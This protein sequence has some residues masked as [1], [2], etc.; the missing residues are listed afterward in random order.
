MTFKN[1]LK[2]VEAKESVKRSATR[3]LH[4]QGSE[5]IWSTYKRDQTY[6]PAPKISSTDSSPCGYCGKIGH[7]KNALI[8][9]RKTVCQAYGKI[10]NFCKKLNNFQS[11]CRRR[12][13]S[14]NVSQENITETA[15]ETIN[16]VNHLCSITSTEAISTVNGRHTVALDHH[17]YDN[18]IDTWKTQASKSQPYINLK[19]SSLPENLQKFGY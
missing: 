12:N 2:L 15:E 18:L 13:A 8:D 14:T 16:H 19:V 6:N 3:L 11:V 9:I 7:G 1:V 5:M 10:C 4:S 17:L